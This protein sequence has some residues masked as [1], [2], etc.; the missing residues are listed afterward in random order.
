MWLGLRE[1]QEE[2]SEVWLEMAA[3]GRIT[4]AK[5]TALAKPRPL[6]REPPV[7]EGS[8]GLSFVDSGQLLELLRRESHKQTVLEGHLPGQTVRAGTVILESGRQG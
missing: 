7:L 1:V 8:F 6:R 4:T 2:S 5:V 3:L